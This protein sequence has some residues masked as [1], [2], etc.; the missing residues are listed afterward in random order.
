[1]LKDYKE[2][3]MGFGETGLEK[4]E[5]DAMS[6]SQGAGVMY[7]QNPGVSAWSQDSQQLLP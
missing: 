4:P 5:G 2:Q 1:M 3:A 7:P 6:L